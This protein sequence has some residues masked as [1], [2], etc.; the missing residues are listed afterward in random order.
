M[1]SYAGRGELNK[2]PAIVGRDQNSRALSLQAGYVASCRAF[3]AAFDSEG[4]FRPRPEIV[5]HRSE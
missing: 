4:N 2:N 5:N 3:S 1:Q